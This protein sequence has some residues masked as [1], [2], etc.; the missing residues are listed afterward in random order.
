[1]D[2][3]RYVGNSEPDNLITDLYPEAKV[4]AVKLRKQV[5][6]TTLKRGTLLE[7][8]SID[9]KMVVLGTTE[10][11]AIEAA[12]ATY[13]ITEDVA[14]AAGKTYYTK[15]GEVYTA[16]E[17]P[18]VANIAT[19]YEMTAAAVQAVA[20]EVLTPAYVLAEDTVVGTA[21]DAVA[22][23]YRS[24]CFSPDHVIVT[25]GYTLTDADVDALR[26]RDIVFKDFMS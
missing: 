19:Y 4:V 11:A 10:A 25:E 7:R 2:L 5:A 23:A 14:I 17:E 26:T 21:E 9:G 6:E 13:A 12:A 20:A 24:G 1:M 8:S 18:D 3:N 22:V 15:S 16:V